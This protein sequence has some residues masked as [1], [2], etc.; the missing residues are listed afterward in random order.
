MRSL[1][2]GLSLLSQFHEAVGLCGCA[3]GNLNFIFRCNRRVEE[4]H[5]G[6]DKSPPGNLHIRRSHCC[7]SGGASCGCESLHSN[8]LVYHALADVFVNCIVRDKSGRAQY[9]GRAAQ[10]S[11]PGPLGI[12]ILVMVG[13]SWQQC[14][15]RDGA[16]QRADFA[17][18]DRGGEAR[19]VC[20]GAADRFIKRDRGR[21]GSSG[22]L[23]LLPEDSRFGCQE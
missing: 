16:V 13:D 11:A 23:H 1:A 4:A 17:G 14:R 21:C 5:H 19:L 15:P 6:S 3:S 2:R 12:E 9:G 10:V 7:R 18:S 20:L 8:G 22:S